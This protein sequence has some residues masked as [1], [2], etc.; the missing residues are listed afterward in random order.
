MRADYLTKDRSALIPARAALF[1]GAP[2]RS[3]NYDF[4][5]VLYATIIA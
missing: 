5:I 2:T 1:P 4:I 3:G